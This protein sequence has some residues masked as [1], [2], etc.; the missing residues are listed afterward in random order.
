VAAAEEG[1]GGSAEGGAEKDAAKSSTSEEAERGAHNIPECANLW[2][3]LIKPQIE[4]IILTS[5]RCVSDSVTHR[6]NTTELFGYDFMLSEGA[7]QPKVWLIEVNSSPACDY[8]T[9]VTCPLVKQ[10]MEDTAKVMVDLR[11]NPDGPTGEWELLQHEH[12]KP[13]K[14]SKNCPV[15][16]E[17][18]GSKVKRPKGWKKKK[19][20]KK[21]AAKSPEPGEDDAGDLE[22]ED[23]GDDDSVVDGGVESDSDS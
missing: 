23:E 14:F 18:C 6:K 19:K 8:S 12:T 21:S 15:N 13:V 10:M 9:P 11:E 4:E 7:E 16:L 20:K 22:E 2:T 3:T 1:H 17:V 5:L